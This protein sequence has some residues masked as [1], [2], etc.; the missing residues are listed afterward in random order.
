MAVFIQPQRSNGNGFKGALLYVMT[1]KA[2]EGE[3]LGFAYVRNMGSMNESDQPEAL[4]ARMRLNVESHR[5]Q[6][7]RT[8]KPAKHFIISF[9]P[10]DSERLTPAILRDYA[11]RHLEALGLSDHEAVIAEHVDTD[12]RHLHLIINKVHPVSGKLWN[13]SHAV[14]KVTEL[15]SELDEK[16]GMTAPAQRGF[17]KEAE[18][19]RTGYTRGADELAKRLEQARPIRSPERLAAFR[20]AAADDFRQA[21]SWADLAERLEAKGLH[22]VPHTYKGQTSL[23]VVDPQ[24]GDYVPT[25]RLG[26]DIRLD[27]LQERLGAFDVA[28]DIAQPLTTPEQRA[29]AFGRTVRQVGAYAHAE[30]I[31]GEAAERLKRNDTEKGQLLGE[32]AAAAEMAREAEAATRADL[33]QLLNPKEAQAYFEEFK[34]TLDAYRATAKAAARPS[35]GAFDAEQ[36]A[37]SRGL[38]AKKRQQKL[39][40][41]QKTRSKWIDALEREKAL[42]EAAAVNRQQRQ[43]LY[44][45]ERQLA[46][47]L[48]P[49]LKG[50]LL[51]KRQAVAAAVRF[52]DLEH[53]PAPQREAARRALA[54]DAINRRTGASGADWPTQDQPTAAREQ[55]AYADY[56][57][58]LEATGQTEKQVSFDDYRAQAAEAAKENARTLEQSRSRGRRIDKGRG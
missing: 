2:A 50:R 42:Q 33:G 46:A 23:R 3:R 57:V 43:N 7:H 27:H 20:G 28:P 4:A 32:M 9:S 14:R 12:H 55:T 49:F 17:S 37:R 24:A 40:K 48:N 41:L 45:E 1:P 36:A 16:H 52:S 47:H 5:N 25:S 11:D 44:Q 35:F 30:K 26:K 22:I 29:A 51:A 6:G 56:A 34:K 38:L 39:A 10:E 31:H 8:K 53:V 19:V 18:Q 15:T 21:T 13:D 54:Q 58:F